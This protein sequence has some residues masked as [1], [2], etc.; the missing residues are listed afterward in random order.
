VAGVGLVEEQLEMVEEQLVVQE[1][2]QRWRAVLAENR[3]NIY[4]SLSSQSERKAF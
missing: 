4:T 3:Q 1:Q 2:P